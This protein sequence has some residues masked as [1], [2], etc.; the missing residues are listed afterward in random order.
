MLYPVFCGRANCCCDAIPHSSITICKTVQQLTK[1]ATEYTGY[2][3]GLL[4]PYPR[5]YGNVHQRSSCGCGA[6][7]HLR[8]LQPVAV[9]V[10]SKRRTLQ[11][12]TE[13]SSLRLKVDPEGKSVSL[14]AIIAVQD[15][16]AKEGSRPP[17][18]KDANVF[19]H[20]PGALRRP[21]ALWELLGKSVLDHTVDHLYRSG[22]ERISIIEESEHQQNN[23]FWREWDRIATQY[24]AQGVRMLLLI[25]LGSYAE[26]D[27]EHLIRAHRQT[28]SSIT[29]V[30]S[31]QRLLD[32]VLVDG[33][34]LR[35]GDG[36]FRG[37]LNSIIPHQRTYDCAG[38][39][40]PLASAQD[41]R[42]LVQDSLLGRTQI[43]PQGQEISSGI[44]CSEGGTIEP[45]A[46]IESPAYLGT[47][48][49]ISALCRVSG[50][51]AIERN[52]KVDY[53][54]VID[55]CC[56]FPDT[57][58]GIGLQ[59]RD[60]LVTSSGLFHLGRNLALDIKDL[61]L[62]A[63]VRTIRPPSGTLRQRAKRLLSRHTSTASASTASSGS[64]SLQPTT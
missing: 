20:L 14:A 55:R 6:L 24:L 51:S 23:T 45:S 2:Q 31:G 8:G 12:Y 35:S 36:S 1:S 56:I 26:V 50:A 7:F 61:R 37:R 28:E 41:F 42:A 49:H 64:A 21:M 44:W 33:K 60:A 54:T 29:Q 58:V 3:P 40:N 13:R 63:N 18:Q 46:K 5:K 30:C 34:K 43:K 39:C 47:G 17:A 19:L 15:G 27:I 32:I 52:C 38:Y 48:V 4:L 9:C 57:Y 53:G 25:R 59:V 10:A 62:F 16:A 22:V 11:S